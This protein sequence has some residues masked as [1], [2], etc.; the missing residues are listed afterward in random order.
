MLGQDV[1]FLE[2]DNK[3]SF[4]ARIQRIAGRK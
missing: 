3:G 2:L 4:W 1:P